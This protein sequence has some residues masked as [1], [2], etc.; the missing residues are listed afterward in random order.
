MSIIVNGI[1]IEIKSIPVEERD[2]KLIGIFSKKVAEIFA[3]AQ[4]GQYVFHESR[5]DE[6]ISPKEIFGTKEYIPY[7]KLYGKHRN[8]GYIYCD[9]PDVSF[10]IWK[11]KLKLKDSVLLLVLPVGGDDILGGSFSYKATLEKAFKCYEEW[12]NPLLYSGIKN[13]NIYRDYDAFKKLVQSELPD[14]DLEEELIVMNCFFLCEEVRNSHSVLFKL[15]FGHISAIR[16]DE[17]IPL[18]MELIEGDPAYK[19]YFPLGF[20]KRRYSLNAKKKHCLYIHRSCKECSG[21]F[22][23]RYSRFLN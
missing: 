22:R 10:G 11:E 16:N 9:N 19:L 15:N 20:Q 8:D 12:E 17:K 1:E 5:P 21:L 14:L 13:E 23:D 4:Y 7:E 18:L 2:D 3:N 6:C